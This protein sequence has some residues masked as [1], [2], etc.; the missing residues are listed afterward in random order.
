MIPFSQSDRGQTA[1]DCG[2][3][4]ARGLRSPSDLRF[5][6]WEPSP[7]SCLGRFHSGAGRDQDAPRTPCTPYPAHRLSHALQGQGAQEGRASS[8]E[9][10]GVGLSKPP[11][12][13][14]IAVTGQPE[15]RAPISSSAKAFPLS[16]TENSPS[17][18]TGPPNMLSPT[19]TNN[20]TG[21]LCSGDILAWGPRGRASQRSL[22]A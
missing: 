19:Q 18:A 2:E 8:W 14:A 3:K 9:G 17:P 6:D 7:E 13:T 1:T 20:T 12:N 5:S 22:Q 11:A 10:N 4:Q 16:G 15:A 21:Q